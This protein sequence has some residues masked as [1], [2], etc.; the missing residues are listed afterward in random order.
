MASALLSL[1]SSLTA[2]ERTLEHAGIKVKAI[3]VRASARLRRSAIR[4]TPSDM[5]C[6]TTGA[7]AS[8]HASGSKALTEGAFS[9]TGG[10]DR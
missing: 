2:P 3:E 8:T 10:S 4:L 5:L 9:T 6:I 7:L 1:K